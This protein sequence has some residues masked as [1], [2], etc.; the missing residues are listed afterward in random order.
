MKKRKVHPSRL[1]WWVVLA[2]AGWSRVATGSALEWSPGDNGQDI[3]WLAAQAHCAALGH[4]WRLPSPQEL[5]GQFDSKESV[6]CGWNYCHV[7]PHWQLTGTWFWSSQRD[8]Q[9]RVWAVN[10][11]LGQVDTSHATPEAGGRAWCVRS[12]E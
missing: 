7:A 5:L 4:G 10:L 6:R 11:D 8:T 3:A 12:V 1:A 2:W 9:G